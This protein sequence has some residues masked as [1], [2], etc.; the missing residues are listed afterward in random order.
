MGSDSSLVQQ[1]YRRFRTLA[2]PIFTTLV[3]EV[4]RFNVQMCA[5]DV[6]ILEGRFATRPKICERGPPLMPSSGQPAHVHKNWPIAVAKSRMRLCSNYALQQQSLQETISQFERFYAHHSIITALKKLQPIQPRQSQHHR[7]NSDLSWMRVHYHPLW[8]KSNLKKT[9]AE[10]CANP[11]WHNP[12]ASVIGKPIHIGIAWQVDAPRLET[13]LQCTAPN[14][15][16][17]GR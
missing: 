11:L 15:A 1:W 14:S 6:L 13:V 17:G 3:V 12:I 10:F 4:S 2:A 8:A 5:V 7:T 16:E 9:V